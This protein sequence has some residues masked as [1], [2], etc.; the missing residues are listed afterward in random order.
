MNQRSDINQR[1]ITCSSK[2]SW[3]ENQPIFVV[4]FMVNITQLH[5]CN[6]CLPLQWKSICLPLYWKTY[7]HSNDEPAVPTHHGKTLRKRTHFIIGGRGEEEKGRVSEWWF[8]ALSAYTLH[9]YSV[10]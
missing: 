6:V 8:H 9:T 10:R 4:K 5:T 1:S 3:M 7:G 2:I